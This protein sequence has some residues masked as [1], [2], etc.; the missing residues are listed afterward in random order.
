MNL[1][2]LL[3]SHGLKS[4][5]TRMA[6]LELFQSGNKVWSNAALLK[7][8]GDSFDRVTL[9]RILGMFEEH[10]LIHKIPDSNGNPSFALCKHEEHHHNHNDHHVHFKCLQC[11]SVRCLEV[12]FPEVHI[13][14]GFKAMKYS[15]LVE[16]I[17][18]GCQK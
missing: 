4:T 16:G 18:P 13:P 3:R 8:L 1:E 10:G 5:N 12:P 14:S 9:Y 7:E 11:E 2:E 6:V 17:C 15:Y